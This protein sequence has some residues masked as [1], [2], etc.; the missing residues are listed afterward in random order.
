[1]V[2]VLLSA[3]L[4]SSSVWVVPKPAEAR[5]AAPPNPNRNQPYCTGDYADD[6]AALST[7]AREFDAKDTAQFSY[8]VRTTATYECIS[9]GADGNLRRTRKR[10][11]AHG[12]AFA[13][14]Q[15]TGET[16]LLTN[17]HVAE[18]PAVT[19][20]DHPVDGVPSGCKKVSD[21]LKIVDNEADA[22]E[23][24][25]IPLQRVVTDN[26][27]DMAVLKAH[28]QLHVMP[29][30]VGRSAALHERNV[31]DVRGFP[32]GAFQ[33]TNV[34][35]VI[36]AYDHDSDKE[37]DHDDF[38]ID[39][40][41]SPGNSGSPV[42]AVSCK[43]GEFELV[44]VYHAGYTGGSAL[45]VVV[46]I[47]QVRDLMT[48]LKRTPRSHSDPQL[49]APARA[50]LVAF[51]RATPEPYFP[52]GPLA[53]VVRARPDGA[54][55]FEL[56]SK[57]F[58]VRAGPMVVLE[59][60][61]PSGAD[62]GQ[63]GRVWFGNRQG[64]KGYLHGELDGDTQAQL[65][66]LLDEL[67]H[68][69]LAAFAFDEAARQGE[70]SREHFDEMS[71]RERALHKAIALRQDVGQTAADLAERLAPKGPEPGLTLAE[72]LASPTPPALAQNHPP[73]PN[74]AKVPALEP[75]PIVPASK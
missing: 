18:W 58:P 60:L 37:W 14:R 42:L 68:D 65:T 16:L 46:G 62:F 27:L 20:D 4:A 63:L 26:T 56:M 38:V 31:V 23:R 45:N 7:R 6:F 52:F 51:V 1:M 32:L 9:Y 70:G 5:P 15:Q 24:D 74:A 64:W 3:L 71:K 22:Y 2:G 35:K 39:A 13:Y 41:L 50:R 10:A 44:G 25:D 49:D 34:G 55:F 67:R 12:T 69:A 8:C 30:K 59:D 73:A 72:V 36:S 54:L 29:W 17:E 28:A 48:T 53:A 75:L 47:D 57:D 66:R 11:Q 61:P 43:T 21:G 40:L 33:A 19:D